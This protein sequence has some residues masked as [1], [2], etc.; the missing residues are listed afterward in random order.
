MSPV[1]IYT[2]AWRE[3]K[4]SKI[5]CLRKQRDGR[6]LNPRPPVKQT[7]KQF[8]LP[9]C[10]LCQVPKKSLISF[11]WPRPHGFGY[12]LNLECLPSTQM[13]ILRAVCLF[14]L[15]RRAKCARHAIDHARRP[16]SSRLK[17]LSRSC[18]PLTKFEEKETCGNLVHR[19]DKEED[20]PLQS[21]LKSAEQ[22]KKERIRLKSN[23]MG[24]TTP[25]S[26]RNNQNFR[27]S[28]VE[29]KVPVIIYRPGGRIWG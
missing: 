11:N 19:F 24:R 8:R 25:F 27:L 21:I 1:P 14:C 6:G 9:D 10:W 22:V 18:T 20:R 28:Y 13:S 2:P 23:G 12:F 29:D 4:W 3:T 16:R 7:A 17:T 5:P 26:N 15:D